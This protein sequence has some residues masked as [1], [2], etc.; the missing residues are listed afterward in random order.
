MKPARPVPTETLNAQARA[1][2]PAIS[3]WVSAN[4]G[5]GKTHVLSQR[6]IRLLLGDTDPARILCLTYTRAAA[7][8]MANRVFKELSAWTAMPDEELANAIESLE[9][10]RPDSAK[11]SLARRL[12]SKALETPGGLKIQTIHAFCESVLHQFPLEANIPA[13]FELMDS[14]LEELLITQARR[15]LI[16]GAADD[17]SGELADAFAKVLERGGESGLDVLLGEIIAQRDGLRRFIT[18]ARFGPEETDRPFA[19]IFE[20]F[21][22]FGNTTA[23]SIA[24]SIWPLPGFSHAEF[25]AFVDEAN[26]AGAGQV[27]K[28]ILPMAVAGFEEQDPVRR[29]ALLASGF[30][31]ADGEPY[32]ERTFTKAL[33]ARMP[34]IAARYAT[35]AAMLSQARD[36]MA[37][38]R[39]LEG[40]V[41][42]LTVAD[43][44]IERYEKL[45]TDRGFLDF[46]DLITRTANLLARQDVGP[47]VQFK[48]DKGIDH[49]LLDEA[50]DTSPEQWNVV[51]RIA[52]EFFVGETAR[53][54]ART[55]FAVGDEKQSIYSFQGAAPK[56][57]AES[58]REFARLVSSANREFSPVRL[59]LSFRSTNDV[60]HAVDRVF[61]RPETRR[62]LSSEAIAHSAW[63]HNEPGYVEVW[64]S[65]GA[66]Q[67]EEPDDWRTPVDHATAP[68][69]RLAA[70]VA[71]TIKKWLDDGDVIEGQNRRIRPGDILVLVRK[72]DGFVHALS[73]NLKELDIAVAGADRLKLVA[74][75]A[76][77][78]M[79]ALGR[80]LL[81]PHDD[82]SLAAV[83][84]SPI[85]GFDEQRLFEIAAGR[86][87]RQTLIGTM[88]QMADQH[89]DIRAAVEMLDRWDTEAAFRPPFE[90]FSGALQRDGVRRRMIA[91]LGHEAGDILDEFLSF[92]L[93]EEQ[94][95]LPGLS[96]FIE[97]LDSAGPEIKREM[98]QTRNEVRIMTVH[99]S[100]G[101]EAPVVFLVDSG[102][103]PFSDHHLPRLMPFRPQGELKHVEGYLWRS[104]AE[105]KNSVIKSI[106]DRLKDLADDEYRRL[107]YVGMTRAEDRLIVCGYHGK[108]DQAQGVWHR[109][110]MEALSTDAR[111]EQRQHPVAEGI[112]VRY[113]AT[114]VPNVVTTPEIA[115]E[116]PPQAVAPA[117]LAPLARPE[118]LP[119]PLSP[120]GAA[121]L[122][123]SALETGKDTRS[124]VLDPQANT[125]FAAA[126]GSAMH[127]MLQTLP[128]FAAQERAEAAKRYLDMVA[129]DWP[130]AERD[131]AWQSVE[132]ILNDPVYGSIFDQGSRAEVAI[133]GTLSVQG[134]DRF[135]SGKIDRLAVTDSSVQII[136]FKT[137]RPA[138]V[139]LDQVPEAYILQLALYAELLKPLYPGKSIRAALLYTEAPRLIELPQ[140]A[141]AAALARLT[142]A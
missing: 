77:Q 75:I 121:A 140:N 85:F 44:L 130:Q 7:A 18:H 61:D 13:H 2:D 66:Q 10:R 117:P 136:D 131:S 34:D 123:E 30:L 142:Q 105:V 1:S 139:T 124:P 125:P 103:A 20:E 126:R 88:R 87:A 39:M 37:L 113:R 5:S 15:D 86:S 111:S 93:A 108:R 55:I 135:V 81:Q 98:D 22:F 51:K 79:M 100:K 99:A 9:G 115:E 110:V 27:Q 46:N 38:F 52:G 71:G 36:R 134:K 104:D 41:A 70:Q 4:A 120:S 48:L 118:L 23:E 82:L 83:L 84:K 94:T 54:V 96:A 114:E 132:V 31:K 138:P 29:L 74:H 107:L 19:P 45:K 67:A 64:D 21:G 59:S 106:R 58:G 101:L 89:E 63:R 72:R 56:S 68:A 60:L 6:V 11:L 47:W 33:V 78:D 137:N 40:T 116:T 109:L 112:V 119:R 133:A 42:A 65:I 14:K 76:V 127:R 17:R 129:G 92:C 53:N 24:Q 43:R 32:G 80:F 141:L 73:R 49:I 3:A 62:G 95:G 25:R 16:S 8:N 128:E 97:T 35:A 57:F 102:S 69:V 26:A 50:Q 12:F 90:F 91:R 122:I 28:Y